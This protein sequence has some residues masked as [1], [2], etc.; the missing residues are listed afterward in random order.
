MALIKTKEQI[1]TLKEGGQILANVLQQITASAQVGV[2]PK[3]LD[4]L[5]EQLINEAGAKPSFKGFQGY[6][7]VLCVSVNEQ[8]VHGI[9]TDRPFEEGD[10]VGIDCGL[11]Y[12]GLCTD[13]AATVIIGAGSK[14]AKELVEVTKQSLAEGLKEIKAGKHLGDYGAAVQNYVEAHG[15]SIIK[16][17]VGHG[18]GTAVHEEPRVPNFGR[19]GSGEVLQAGM[20]LALE[21]MVSVGSAQIITEADGW[22]IATKDRS[23][24]AHFEVTVA[25]TEEGYELITPMIWQ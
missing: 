16:G 14:I 22:T 17:L 25:V 15:F 5:A 20:V 9:P 4:E 23:L 10:V 13:M 11:W 7:A 19:P 1:A 21:P 24:S 12:K 8:L 18:V 3:K 6:P 2:T